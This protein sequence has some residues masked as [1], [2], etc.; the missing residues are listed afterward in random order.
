MKND[1]YGFTLLE[2]VVVIFII[3]LTTALIMP[4][5]LDSADNALR[6]EAKHISSTMRYVYDEATAR[7]ET[8]LF[9]IYPEKGSWGFK[10]NKESRTFKIRDNVKFKD[11]LIPSVGEFTR[12]DVRISFSPL[13]PDE[14]IVLH[15]TS[16]GK[17]ITIIFNNLN[18]RS[19]I[20]EGYII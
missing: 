1:K 18:G 7:K 10:G 17:D 5:F 8:Y 11:V 13:G 12:K 6:S 14:P 4:S 20:L 2:L 16:N 15:L 19:R 3:S 9:S